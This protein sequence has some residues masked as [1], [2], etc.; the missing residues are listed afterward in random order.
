MKKISYVLIIRIAAIVLMLAALTAACL[1]SFQ[2]TLPIFLPTEFIGEYSLDNGETWHT[3]Q[4]DTNVPAK[5]GS[6][7]LKGA[8]SEENS[9]RVHIFTFT[10]IISLWIYT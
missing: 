10:L 7:I 9:P 1:G 8:A 6:I 5:H 3:L 2:S 4:K